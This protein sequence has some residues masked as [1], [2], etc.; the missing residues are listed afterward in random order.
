MGQT[1]EVGNECQDP[2]TQVSHR[3]PTRTSEQAANQDAEPDLNLVEPG[4]VFGSVDEANTMA[5]VGEQS[6]TC[7]HV[8]EV[9]AFAFHTQ[10]L[11]DVTLR[12]HQAH[13]GLGLMGA[14]VDR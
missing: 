10:V 11:L 6:S 5:G 4:T 8:G 2:F 12:S 3:R 9:A 7:G 14:L 13:Q 1:I